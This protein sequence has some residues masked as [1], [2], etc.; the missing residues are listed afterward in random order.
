MGC[1]R[2]AGI[3]RSQNKP[4]RHPLEVKEGMG[5]IQHWF[6][7]KASTTVWRQIA[8][9]LSDLVCGTR[10][11]NPRKLQSPYSRGVLDPLPFCLH[12]QLLPATPLHLTSS[13]PSPTSAHCHPRFNL[14]FHLDYQKGFPV[15]LLHIW[16]PQSAIHTWRAFSDSP[17]NQAKPLP[18]EKSCDG[19]GISRI[20]TRESLFLDFKMKAWTL[21]LEW[22][23]AP[24]SHT[25]YS[26]SV[27]I[28]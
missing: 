16:V 10:Y 20:P 18:S 2:T 5:L 23:L 28:F 1:P 24:H 14:S 21:T 26:Q 15:I 25:L 12:S 17:P 7:I 6:W 13:L 4:G 9:T 22:H 19:Y 8:I 3:I 27:R 11:G